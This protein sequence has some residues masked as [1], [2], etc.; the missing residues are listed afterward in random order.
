MINKC[1]LLIGRCEYQTNG[2]CA[3][4]T[5]CENKGLAISKQLTSEEVE[6]L[7]LVKTRILNDYVQTI[8]DIIEGI[9]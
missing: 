1:K 7:V 4:E 8:K 9:V 6:A 3:A 5:P 2:M